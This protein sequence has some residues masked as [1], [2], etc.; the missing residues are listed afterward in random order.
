[1]TDSNK[2]QQDRIMRLADGILAVLTG[3]DSAEADTA[4][5]LVVIASVYWRTS[6]VQAA[7]GFAQQVRELVQHED[8]IER[9]ETLIARA[10]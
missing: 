10:L 9:I 8:I 7:D 3:A 1:M 2:L 5:A 4:L 6:D